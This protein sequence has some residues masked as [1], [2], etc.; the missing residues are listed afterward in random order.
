MV[1]QR[2]ADLRDE[3][4]SSQVENERVSTELTNQNALLDEWISEHIEPL[5]LLEVNESIKAPKRPLEHSDDTTTN[6]RRRTEG[7]GRNITTTA[8][9]QPSNS[10]EA[11]CTAGLRRL[12]E[13]A[14]N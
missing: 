6:K 14:F 3:L 4:F 9:A 12:A 7:P 10:G 1:A 8:P 5:G 2:S 11:K 13:E